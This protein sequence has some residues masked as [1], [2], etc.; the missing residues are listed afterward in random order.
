MIPLFG[1]IVPLMQALWGRLR[2][3]RDDDRGMTTEAVII[4]AALAALALT[5]TGIIV[6]RVTN[7]A[8]TIDVDAP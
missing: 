2:D 5:V 3:L 7:E 8:N 4:T 1:V 6:V